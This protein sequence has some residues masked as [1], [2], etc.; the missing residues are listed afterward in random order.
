MGPPPCYVPEKWNENKTNKNA[1][2]VI[3]VKGIQCNNRNRKTNVAV[4]G[5][6]ARVRGCDGE[7]ANAN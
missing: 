6:D 2:E 4:V 1:F 3:E 7:D 5:K